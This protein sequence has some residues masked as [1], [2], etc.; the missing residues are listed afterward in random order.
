[1][2]TTETPATTENPVATTEAPATTEKPAVT[3]EA[4]ATTEKPAATTEVPAT[5]EKP[6]ATTEAPATTERPAATTETA[7]IVVTKVT[8]DKNKL[9]LKTGGK[10]T[11]KATVYPDD[12]SNSDVTWSSDKPSVATV[13]K[14]G[15][16]T[17]KKAGTATITCTAE[18]GSGKK[19][20]CKVTVTDVKVKK[21]TL[22]NTSVLR[23]Q[24]V[25]LKVKSI[26]PSN[27]TNKKVTWSS[28]DKSIA[29]VDKNGKVTAKKKGN[30]TITCT[31]ADG[32]K[33][34]AT[35]KVTVKQP[36]TKITLS[37]TKVTLKKGKTITLKKTIAPSSANTKT[38][39]WKSSNKKVATVD[40][41]GK[42]K[43]VGKGTA[44]ITCTAKDGSG[45]KATC[46][47]T[48]TK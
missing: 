24:T 26:T 8:L 5:T 42:V 36:V 10:S 31:A 32:S 28:S 44:T 34:K 46:K 4:P 33:T 12:A 25:T 15:K 2:T 1:V 23:G 39:I 47:V 18:D 29:T 13:D 27:A 3:T 40:S 37:K 35:C 30:V 43:A 41:N 16:V 21:I 20:T 38:V 45:K 17:A 19:A 48:V 7:K 22:S 9:S 6:A 14:N 11:L